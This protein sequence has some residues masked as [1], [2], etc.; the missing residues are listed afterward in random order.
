MK[1]TE[2][3]NKHLATRISLYLLLATVPVLIISVLIISAIAA[4]TTETN[5]VITSA[6]II[7][8]S[9]AIIIFILILFIIKNT[10]INPLNQIKSAVDDLANGS[11]DFQNTYTKNDE[12][13]KILDFLSVTT[14]NFKKLSEAMSEN[15]S[16]LATSSAAMEDISNKMSTMSQDQAAFMEETSASLEET[17]ASMEQ[18]ANQT[19]TQYQNVDK[20][21]ERM[22]KMAEEARISY[23]E[24]V[25]VNQQMEKTAHEARDGEKDLNRM[26]EEMS[27]IKQSTSKIAEIIKI[28]SDISEQVNLLSLNAAIEAARA[29]EHGRGFAVVADEISKLADETASSAKTIS[30]LVLEGDA[31]VDSGTEIVNKTAGAFHHI[32]EAIETATISMTKF[33]D[34]LQSVSELSSEARGRT[35]NIKQISNDIS[36]AAREQM[37]TTQD[38]SASIEKVNESS[39]ELVTFADAIQKS[40]EEIKGIS[41]ILQDSTNMRKSGDISNR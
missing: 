34:T 15:I 28:I 5:I 6:A 17:R 40:A 11:F 4:S 33:S 38:I 22:G 20:N 2:F 26:V 10:V 18:I 8:I 41:N 16:N 39:Q 23:D 37:S 35:D 13:G 7:S 3:I 24:A 12:I 31:Q 9:A 29:G 36:V 25:R 30:A 27:N 32:I 1:L 19:E 21:A 14:V